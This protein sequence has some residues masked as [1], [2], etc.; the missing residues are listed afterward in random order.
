MIITFDTS[1]ICSE[2]LTALAELLEAKYHSC[3]NLSGAVPTDEAAARL[4]QE[5]TEALDKA[6]ACRAELDERE[7]KW[8]ELRKRVAANRKAR[9]TD[10]AVPHVE[11]RRP[12]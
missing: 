2:S 10:A 7:A 1:K 3:M 9:A 6:K 8:K 11:E 4:E 5:A 12:I